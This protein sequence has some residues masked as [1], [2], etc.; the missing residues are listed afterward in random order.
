M[1][2]DHYPILS[3]FASFDFCLACDVMWW[4]FLW[5]DALNSLHCT[6][7]LSGSHKAPSFSFSFPSSLLP[8]P[9]SPLLPLPLRPLPLLFVALFPVPRPPVSLSFPA[10]PVSL[11]LLLPSPWPLLSFSPSLLSLSFF[12]FPSFLPFFF[13]FPIDP[14]VVF[15]K[16]QESSTCTSSLWSY[17]SF[18]FSSQRCCTC[19]W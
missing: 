5:H 8:P 16:Y 14:L 12:P 15:E 2:H 1:C 3:S 10:S 11:F 13:P 7:H 9:C 18:P 4:S 17:G 6:L 19:G